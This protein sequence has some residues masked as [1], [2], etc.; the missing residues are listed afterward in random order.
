MQSENSRGHWR[1]PCRCCGG[2]IGALFLV[3]AS[4]MA[5]ADPPVAGDDA[6]AWRGLWSDADAGV[7]EFR[8]IPFA[9]PPLGELRWRAPQPLPDHDSSGG[10]RDATRFAAACMQDDGA[11]EWY[12]QVA[13]AFGYSAEVVARPQGVSEDC[14][15]LNIWTPRPEPEAA[16]PVIVFVHGGGNTGGW[17][18]EPNYRGGALANRGVV[19]VTVA[20]RLGPLGFFA[21]PALNNGPG[22][23]VANFGL[24]DL[25]AAFQWIRRHITAFGGDANKITAI[26]ESAGALNLLD[27]LLAD[28]SRMQSQ[29]AGGGLSFDR[30][31]SQSIG[32][33]LVE[34]ESLQQE[35]VFGARM[36]AALGLDSDASAADLRAVAAERWVAAIR[37]LPPDYYPDSVVDGL[38]LTRYPLAALADLRAEGIELIL[39]SNAD[40]WRMYLDPETSQDDLEHWIAPYDNPA[41]LRAEVADLPD[42]RRALDRLETWRN[43]EC[44]S[45]LIADWANGSG[46]RAWMYRF[47]RVRAG[48]GGLA[49]GAYHGAEL[50]YVFDSHDG[51]LDTAAQDRQ[52]GARMMS[53]W[54]AFARSGNPNGPGRPNWPAYRPETCSVLELGEE[55]RLRQPESPALCKALGFE[56]L[57]P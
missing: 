5:A 7:A 23:P 2:L 42:P 57:L 31:V 15:Y 3:Q 26:G 51:W 52:L 27:L 19:V 6:L 33:P 18:Y 17:S 4:A 41:A 36:A 40:E 39:G 22:H 14:L 13:A 30:L 35:Q 11:V 56:G 16:L 25:R 32:G 20:Y 10:P 49:L 9:R 50:P 34:R 38:T 45:R 46:G 37:S 54:V 43:M 48:A 28:L 53:Y 21:H 1:P 47:T 29:T 12:V 55:I 24:L 8:G 44:P